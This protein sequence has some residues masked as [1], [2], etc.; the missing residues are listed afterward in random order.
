MRRPDGTLILVAVLLVL[1]LLR[2]SRGLAPFGEEPPAFSA[3]RPG[4]VT[5]YL[6]RGFPEPGFHHFID[7]TGIVGVTGMAGYEWDAKTLASVLESPPLRNGEALNMTVENLKVLEVERYFVPAGQRVALG[8]PLHPDT[9][10][11]SGWQALPGIGPQLAERIEQDRQKNGD[12]GTLEALQRVRGIGT[13]IVRRIRPF[14]E[15][16]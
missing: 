2:V 15:N 10:R 9:L 3:F 11:A 12:F 6:N 4:Y 5:I 13:G 16:K 8:I 1:L 7:G 14:F